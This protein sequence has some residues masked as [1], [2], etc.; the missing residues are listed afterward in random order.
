MTKPT[1]SKHLRVTEINTKN[2]IN[3]QTYKNTQNPPVYTNTMG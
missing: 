2:T 1:V 3:T